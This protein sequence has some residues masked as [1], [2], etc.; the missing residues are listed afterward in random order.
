MF[1]CTEIMR[2]AMYLA[3]FC[4]ADVKKLHGH[5]LQDISEAASLFRRVR[6]GDQPHSDR[7]SS[8]WWRRPER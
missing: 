2:R 6:I 7:A 3:L 4:C 1:Q 8:I 5:Q